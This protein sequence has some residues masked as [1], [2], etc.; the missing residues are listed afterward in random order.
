MSIHVIDPL[1]EKRW[2]EFVATHPRASAFHQ[3][4]WLRALACTYGYK[5][6]VL[7]STPP[8]Q[9]LRDGIVLCGVCS[10]I[11]GRRLVSLPFADHC[12]PLLGD[13]DN[14]QDFI[15][16]LRSDCDR[17]AYRYVELRPVRVAAGRCSG[18]HPSSSFYFHELDLSPSLG[19]MFQR[20]HKDSIRRKIR[21]AERE[22]LSCTIGRSEHLLEEFYQLL[23]ITRRRHQLPPQPRIWFQNL[24]AHMGNRVQVMV[25]KKDDTPIAALITLRHGS[26][27][28]YKYGC[29]DDKFHS[30]GAM[31]FLLWRLI[32]ESKDAGAEKIDLGRSDIDNDGLNTFKDRFGAKKTMLTYYRYPDV[33]RDQKSSGRSSLLHRLVPFMPDAALRI[34]GALL[35]KHMG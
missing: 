31:P 14:L 8:G 6:F 35:Y 15:E 17:R 2:D 26:S 33:E 10:W 34:A 27:V 4:G 12:D 30:L 28:V 5:P 11:T 23:L 25:A 16:W 20:L 24:V 19:E 29:S 22:Q 7:T 1:A 21:R 3:T 13:A 9:T 32:Q 18:L